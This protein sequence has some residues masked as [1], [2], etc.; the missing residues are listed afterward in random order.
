VYGVVV[1]GGAGARPRRA[2]AA[3][4][5]ADR[6]G[7]PPAGNPCDSATLSTGTEG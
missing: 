2:A 7:H 4:S 6:V 1:G 5:A 3:G